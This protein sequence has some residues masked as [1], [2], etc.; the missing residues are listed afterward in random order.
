MA[1]VLAGT[2]PDRRVPGAPLIQI[3]ETFFKRA[4]LALLLGCAGLSLGAQEVSVLYGGLRRVDAGGSSFS[5]QVDYRQDLFRNL[6]ASATYLNEGHLPGHHRDGEALQAWGRVPFR[7]GRFSLALGAG[8][9]YYFDTQPRPGGGSADVHSTAPILSLSATGQLSDRWFCRG[10]V[11][12]IAPA[13]EMRTVTAAVGLGF[14]F[15]RNEL[16]TPGQLGDAP[17]IKDLE[18]AQDFTVLAGQSVVNT[19]FSPAGRAY[20]L[21]YR[22]GLAR[23]LDWTASL[24][25]EGNP[26][27]VRRSGLASQGWAVNDFFH[28]RVAFGIGFGP[29]LYVDRKH[30]QAGSGTPA[31]VAGLGSLTLSARL[32]EAWTARL[33]FDRVMSNYDRD[34]DVFLLGLGYRWPG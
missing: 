11:N 24:I 34:A 8:A 28:D 27:I 26:L 31:R 18:L 33:L 23:H 25:Y 4:W 30:P 1:G 2:C 7:D 16:P 14:W 5:Y 15:G 32:T 29:Y 22:R 12:H 10:V 17:S 21:E 19:F 3:H 20:A 13:H 6:A 9:Y